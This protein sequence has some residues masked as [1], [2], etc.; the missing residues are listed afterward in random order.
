[1]VEVI[2]GR[3]IWALKTGPKRFH[4]RTIKAPSS[5]QDGASCIENREP[6]SDNFHNGQGFR[7]DSQ[8]YFL[9]SGSKS[10]PP[11]NASAHSLGPGMPRPYGSAGC[12]TFYPEMMQVGKSQ[13]HGL[14]VREECLYFAR[15]W[16]SFFRFYCFGMGNGTVGARIFR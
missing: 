4:F 9:F 13:G 11:L 6:G 5:I 7:K 12:I 10:H 1:M 8:L 15:G 2:S 3:Y 16:L 14:V